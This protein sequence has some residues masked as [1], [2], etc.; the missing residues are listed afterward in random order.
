MSFDQ[1][2]TITITTKRAPAPISGIRD[3]RASYLTNVDAHPIMP[4]ESRRETEVRLRFGDSRQS[5]KI[6]QTYIEKQAHTKSGNPVTELPDI[7]ETDAIVYGGIEYNIL[8]VRT[9]PE[10]D[11][12]TPYLEIVLEEAK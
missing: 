12:M 7:V 11:G 10:T 6:H 4:I 1:L 3:K 8:A 9:W 2:A 5:A